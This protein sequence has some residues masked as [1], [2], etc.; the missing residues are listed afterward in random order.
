[1]LPTFL[2]QPLIRAFNTLLD[3]EPWAQEKLRLHAGK[4]VRLELGALQLNLCIDTN[5]KVADGQGTPNV[6]VT[7]KASDIPRF[8]SAD[9]QQRMHYVRIDG[10]VALAH[11]VAD[12][13]RDLRWDVEDD[14]AS[15]IGDIPARRLLGLVRDV[16]QGARGGAERLAQNLAEYVAHETRL[17]VDRP[18]LQDLAHDIQQLEHDVNRVHARISAWLRNRGKA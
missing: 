15:V 17:V 7:I 9:T 10:E 18:S 3:R 13:A 5:G 8:A 4:L 1:M 12:L 2:L 14:L 16:T 11:L 6:T